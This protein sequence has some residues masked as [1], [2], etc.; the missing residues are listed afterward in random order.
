MLCHSSE[1]SKNQASSNENENSLTICVYSLIPYDRDDK[2][3]ATSPTSHEHT[4]PGRNSGIS[5]FLFAWNRKI[6]DGTDHCRK[7]S[8]VHLQGVTERPCIQMTYKN[9]EKHYLEYSYFCSD[10]KLI[11]HR[12]LRVLSNVAETE[13]HR[14]FRCS[15]T[16]RDTLHSEV[17]WS[18][19]DN[20]LCLT[21]MKGQLNNCSYQL[22]SQHRS[23]KIS[24]FCR[25]PWGIL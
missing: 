5:G 8:L 1:P 18:Y 15:R 4:L 17:F 9:T 6:I 24:C 12:T 13:L 19:T 22:L 21:K 20:I 14:P 25:R 16:T 3:P 7:S 10:P 11:I 23:L 2:N